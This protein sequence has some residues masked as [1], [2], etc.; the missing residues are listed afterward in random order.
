MRVQLSALTVVAE[1]A[2]SVFGSSV[3]IFFLF[4]DCV[5]RVAWL[6]GLIE[7]NEAMTT[8]RHGYG[9]RETH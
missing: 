9:K 4:F 3:D 7:L 6:Y 2:S 8:V 1:G 5:V